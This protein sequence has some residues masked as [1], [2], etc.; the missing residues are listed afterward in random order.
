MEP[1]EAVMAE[2]LAGGVVVEE[3]GLRES[4]LSARNMV[5]KSPGAC[6]K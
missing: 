5:G 4:F 6:S 3:E 2:R 1:M